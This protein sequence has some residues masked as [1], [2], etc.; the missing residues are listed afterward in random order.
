M[1]GG[2]IRATILLLITGVLVVG[3][4]AWGLVSSRSVPPQ[5]GD[6]VPLDGGEFIVAGAFVVDDPM[7]SMTAANS[8][9]FA[10]SGMSMSQM[11][12]DAVP[13]GMKRVAVE[14]ILAAGD[15]EMSFP[16][17]GVRLVAGDVTYPVY[18]ALLGDERLNPKERLSGVVTFEV[19]VETTTALFT[20]APET[21]AVP[22]NVAGGQVMDMDHGAPTPTPTTS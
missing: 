13:E 21:P 2:S 15:E 1:D 14:L 8:Q 16:T 20:L 10:M 19:P 17:D 18:R 9:Q 11:L 7:A 12:P 3:L 5:V 6:P 22:V 4:A